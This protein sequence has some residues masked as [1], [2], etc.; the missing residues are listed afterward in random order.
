[1]REPP[2]K[3]PPMRRAAKLDELAALVRMELTPDDK[4][5]D[6]RDAF[7]PYNPAKQL[8]INGRCN[9][10]SYPSSSNAS[11]SNGSHGSN[12][13]PANLLPERSP[14][15]RM[16]PENDLA[17]ASPQ[18]KKSTLSMKSS[19][20]SEPHATIPDGV[21]V[22]QEPP[23]CYE[24]DVNE[25]SGYGHLTDPGPSF[26]QHPKATKS[27][28]RKAE[29]EL[30][31]ALN[32]SSRCTRSDTD[33]GRFWDL[34]QDEHFCKTCLFEITQGS[35]EKEFLG[36]KEEFSQHC[37]KNP[38]AKFFVQDKLLPFWLRCTQCHKFR[39]VPSKEPLEPT[40]IGHFTC[41]TLS[42]RNS[43]QDVID[44]L[45][46]KAWEF[47]WMKGSNT[48]PLLI[49]SPALPFISSKSY[50]YDLIGMSPAQSHFSANME[51]ISD[52][53]RPFHED[54]K[55]PAALVFGAGD[56]EYDEK[57]KFPAFNK[58]SVY[59]LA[60]RNLIVSLW[61]LDPFK[62]LTFSECER[63]LLCRG[64][65]R[66][67]Y[68]RLLRLVYDFLNAH[69]IINIGALSL[70]KLPET[71]LNR[72]LSV[73]IVG[74]G[75]SG[76]TAARQLRS[77]GVNVT[78]LE[79]KNRIGGRM[80]DEYGLGST[81]GRGAQIVTGV[82]NSPIVLICKQKGFRYRAL[83]DACPTFDSTTGDI[84]DYKT[85][86]LASIMYGAAMD[87][88][89]HWR[90]LKKKDHSLLV[91]SIITYYLVTCGCWKGRGVD[92]GYNNT[93]LLRSRELADGWTEYEMVVVTDL[94]TESKEP[95]G[96]K[97][98]SNARRGFLK[99]HKKDHK[100][101]V[102]WESEAFKV[103]SQLASGGR[104]M[105]LSDLAIFDG[106]LLTV[107]DRTGIVYELCTSKKDVM[108]WLLL[109]D[110]PGRT[111]KTLKGEWMT[112]KDQKLYVGG[113]GKEWT[114][115]AGEYVN[116]NPMWVKIVDRHGAVEHVNWKDIFVKVRRALGIEYPGY[117]IHEAVQWSDVHNKWFFLPRRASNETYS[118]EAD[119]IRGTN[120]MI[121]VSEDFTRFDVVSIGESN[122]P[123]TG[124]S[125]FQFV[126][127]TKDHVI[128]ALKSAEKDGIPVAS[129][130]SVF[131][132]NGHILLQDQLLPETH[133]SNFD[134]DLLEKQRVH[135]DESSLIRM[136]PL[137][138]R[139]FYWHVAN[140]E[141]ACGAPLENVSAS[142]WDQNEALGQFDGKHS[143]LVDGAQKVVESLSEGTDIL[144]N[145]K[146]SNI[147]LNNRGVSVI[148]QDGTELQADKVLVTVP[149]AILK[150]NTITFDPPLPKRKLD[151]IER[152]GAGRIEKVAVAFPRCFWRDAKGKSKNFDY[153][154]HVGSVEKRG[155]FHTI[156]DFT[157]RQDGPPKSFVLM[158]YVC[159]QS[160]ALIDK[161]KD[162][163]VIKMF[164]DTLKKIFPGK[165]I[166]KPI[167]HMV[168][169]WGKD[170]DIGMSYSYM[171][172][173]SKPEDYDS[174]AAPAYDR[175]FFA[176][177][178]T[179][180]FF[181]QTMHGAYLSG[182]RAATGILENYLI[183]HSKAFIDG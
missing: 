17:S 10:P 42:N 118:E 175:I 149:L 47:N 75:L 6:S 135:L 150:K 129:Y 132:V 18:S 77:F 130:A 123:R 168:S 152:V 155:L 165:Q 68:I 96:K 55:D 164:I 85:D 73:L 79:A 99:Y 15:A 5:E 81:V 52:W 66:I 12:G 67:W 40:A 116:D 59:Y 137:E 65:S 103:Y 30:T 58:E 154:A 108:P 57:L 121:V 78:V 146:V 105:E 72:R 9:S 143:L 147:N 44:P 88:V 22:K 159:G 91:T 139:I 151:A 89:V 181:P 182:L 140:S 28:K 148:L 19:T 115:P 102:A 37:R 7:V 49:N 101:S 24:S 113:L 125:A 4:D 172:V 41:G 60:V 2:I 171:G 86:E 109:N 156:Y 90:T 26:Q 69:G 50:Y 112:V 27:R 122:D 106:K 62:Y 25:P 174:L 95:N 178:A 92:S 107:D 111:A 29:Q 31:C 117:M 11:S 110:G 33:S 141:Y 98:H 153:F 1:M 131:D 45:A 54:D 80:N 160:L 51:K 104:A 8:I 84:I 179:H 136:S 76:L 180:R 63:H 82:V 144:L 87:G 157:N 114:T 93:Q 176:G 35:L 128:I 36:W 166:P 32:L 83:N 46:A 38:G 3:R 120:K 14:A 56:M 21:A 158:S 133:K 13:L 183:D 163:E 43:C 170:E 70:P 162:E 61:T 100:A 39:N 34:N 145:K 161:K 138:K 134:L 127:G 94:D 167:S 16:S 74:A 119:E 169:R 97:W 177:E 48:L 124:F 71:R 142:S 20:K 173:N 53:A 23:D 126:P 64:L